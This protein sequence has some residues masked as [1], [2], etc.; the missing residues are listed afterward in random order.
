MKFMVVMIDKY[1]QTVTQTVIDTV[2]IFLNDPSVPVRVRAL[3]AFREIMRHFPE[4]V[5]RDS[6]NRV[7]SLHEDKYVAVHKTAAGLAH[8]LMPFVNDQEYSVLLSSL[9]NLEDHY[10]KKKDFDFC[11]DVVRALLYITKER[12]K[13]YGAVVTT[14]LVKYCNCGDYYTDKKFI[15]HLTE[16]TEE[17]NQFHELWLAQAVPFLQKTKPDMY[18]R[19]SDERR[20]LFDHLYL[21]GHDMISRALEPI[22]GFIKSRIKNDVFL[23]V[24]DMLAVLCFYG[25]NDSVYELSEYLAAHVPTTASNKGVHQ[26]NRAIHRMIV[27]E[28]KARSKQID[29]AWLNVLI[30]EK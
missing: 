7:L 12:P 2:K 25:F 18:N 21:E 26:M 27:T 9:M 28:R 20:R 16:I 23:D 24:F 13:V 6:I 8:R 29:E 17:S 5:D 10:F 3:E 15:G 4:Q 30:N 1:P 19:W 22:S 14:I 11:E